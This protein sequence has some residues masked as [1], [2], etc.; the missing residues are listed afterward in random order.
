M[1]GILST[2][3]P[4]LR[5][6]Y[7]ID[8]QGLDQGRSL[9]HRLDGQGSHFDSHSTLGRLPGIAYMDLSREY[10]SAREQ[11]SKSITIHLGDF[12]GSDSPL[13][14]IGS[15]GFAEVAFIDI[16]EQSPQVDRISYMQSHSLFFLASGQTGP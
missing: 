4:Q 15:T 11:S 9:G 1:I 2:L 5:L 7:R 12:G 16:N 8:Q 14:A 13:S 6:Q 10:S 3:T